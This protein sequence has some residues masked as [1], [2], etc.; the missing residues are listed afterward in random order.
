MD[1][2]WHLGTPIW[3]EFLIRLLKAVRSCSRPDL[4]NID[5]NAYTLNEIEQSKAIF[6]LLVSK[7]NKH[8]SK[9]N[10]C[11]MKTHVRYIVCTISN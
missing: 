5:K 8:D 6:D 7:A 9:M 1:F 3:K 10:D 2:D 11:I 4:E